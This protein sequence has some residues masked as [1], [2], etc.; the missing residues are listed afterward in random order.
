MRA[1]W[2][3]WTAVGV[4]LPRVEGFRDGHDV[5]RLAVLE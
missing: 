2:A 5:N 1:Y 4:S 3:T